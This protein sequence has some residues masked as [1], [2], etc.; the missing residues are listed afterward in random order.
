MMM[1]RRM[2]RRTERTASSYIVEKGKK[3]NF[4][5]GHSSCSRAGNMFRTQTGY[6]HKCVWALPAFSRVPNLNVGIDNLSMNRCHEAEIGVVG[7][8]K[9]DQPQQHS[10]HHKI[11]SQHNQEMHTKCHS[12]FPSSH[13]QHRPPIAWYTSYCV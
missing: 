7:E 11:K 13:T 12:S 3:A 9:E 10:Q 6:I 8:T 1:R 2:R 5:I 4:W